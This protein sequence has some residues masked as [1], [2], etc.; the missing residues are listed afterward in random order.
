MKQKLQ[1]LFD[2]NNSKQ[3]LLNIAFI[4]FLISL[5]YHFVHQIFSTY[6]FESW[7][8]TEFLI[9]Y[10][11]GFVRRGLLGEIL[12][13]LTKHFNADVE[14]MIK[15]MCIV[16][17]ALICTFFIKS[18]LKNSYCLYILPLCFFLGGVIIMPFWIGKD[19]LM[20]CFLIAILWIYKNKKL[21]TLVKIIF[22]NILAVLIIL[23]HEIFAF[24]SLPVLFLCFLQLYKRKSLFK[25]IIYSMITLFPVVFTFL[26]AILNHGNVQIAQ[27]IWDSWH[28]LTNQEPTSIGW[29]AVGAIAWE[30]GWAM[31]MHFN[32]NF[33]SLSE[34]G[35][36]LSSVVWF[37]TIPLVY[38]ISTNALF[39]FQKE[40]TNLTE[41]HKT[42]LSS[43]F[44]FQFLCLAP[45]FFVLSCDYIRLIYY[46]VTS[47]F[48]IF[49]LI[50]IDILD[51]IFHQTFI[52]ITNKT[53]ACLCYFVRPTRTTMALLMIFI[54]ISN[55]YGFQ[56][57]SALK[58]TLLY[59]VLWTLSKIFF[60]FQKYTSPLF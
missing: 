5:L 55:I 51:K 23:I 12:F 60:T 3:T 57:F 11:A 7:Q 4:L 10:Q 42:I 48:A 24:F 27:T 53:N 13:V 47:S 49:L 52:N 41:N 25:S 31:N 46:W 59:N 6:T 29:N 2:K 17:Y 30:V 58:S 21:S 20:T 37:F 19:C 26:I 50:P 1:T 9:N 43:I 14:W 8:I 34:D 44:L 32:V 36:V 40:G 33:L 45:V 39:V 38:Y 22:I 35:L 56:L 54:G 28:I 15:I 18:F 16:C